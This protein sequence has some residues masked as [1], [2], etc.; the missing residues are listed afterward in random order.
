LLVASPTVHEIDFDFEQIV[1]PL[2][3][4]AVP[5]TVSVVLV[6]L[7]VALDADSQNYL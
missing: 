4:F 3:F 2:L 6:E 7:S 5:L 1:I